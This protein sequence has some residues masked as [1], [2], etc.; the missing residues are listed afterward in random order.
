MIIRF[1]RSVPPA[2]NEK[3]ANSESLIK[4]QNGTLEKENPALDLGSN[5]GLLALVET[6]WSFVCSSEILYLQWNRKDWDPGAS[7]T[8]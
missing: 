5:P 3:Q 7:A 2:N 8:L 1:Y 4:P 6:P